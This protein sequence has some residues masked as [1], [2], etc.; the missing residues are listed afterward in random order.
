[1]ELI[2]CSVKYEIILDIMCVDGGEISGSEVSL[3]LKC[4]ELWP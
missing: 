1:M 2:W 3:L 4:A